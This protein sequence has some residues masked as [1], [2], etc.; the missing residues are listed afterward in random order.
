MKWNKLKDYKCPKCLEDLTRDPDT[1]RFNCLGCNEFSISEKRFTEI[2]TQ[3]FHPW[4]KEGQI[5]ES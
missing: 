4:K 3:E 5:L 1:R 2:V